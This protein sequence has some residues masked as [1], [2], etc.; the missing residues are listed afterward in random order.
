MPSCN[1]CPRHCNIDRSRS[2]GFCGVS[3]TLKAARADLHFWEEPC[4]CSP[5]G[6]AGAIF[7]SGCNLKCVFCQNEKISRGHE[8]KEISVG[9]LREIIDELIDKGA[10][11]IDLV[12][13]THFTD[14]IINALDGHK[15]SVPVVWNSSG[16]ESVDTLRR[17]RG[18]VDIYL[19]DYKYS[20]SHLAKKLSGAE[21]YPAVAKAALREMFRQTGKFR[22]DDNGMMLS[23]VIVRHL[24]LPGFIEN[25]LSCLDDLTE[26]FDEDD[27]MISLMSQY[28]PPKKQLAIPSLNRRLTEKEYNSAVDYLYLLGRDNG[29]VQELS[30]AEEEYTPDFDGTGV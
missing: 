5:G 12:T 13:P 25:T 26:M 4:I 15:P 1:L 23:G 29:F 9:R 30:S 2:V 7:F 16:Y 10:D 14:I 21:D 18:L 17:L 28:T 3:S 22:L 24:V 20:D 27:I 11:T 19:P 8:G 6:G